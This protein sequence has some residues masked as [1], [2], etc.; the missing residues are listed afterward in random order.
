MNRLATYFQ[1]FAAIFTLA[2]WASSPALAQVEIEVAAGDSTILAAVSQAN[3]GDIL[4]LTTDG[5]L[6]TN[7]DEIKPD[8]PLTIKAADG[9][10]N[11]PVLQNT[12]PDGTKDIIRLYSDLTLIGLE[13]D[14]LNEAKYGIRTGSGSGDAAN[15]KQGYVLKIMDCYFHDIVSGADGN[16]FRAYGSTLA[17]SI[18]VRNSLFE[19]MGKEGVRVRDEDSD[20]RGFGFYNVN[21]F[22][23]SHSTFWDIKNDA[24]S[25][26]GGDEDPN[27]PG[28]EV[29]IDHVTFHNAGHYVINLKDVEDAQVTNSILVGNYDIV[30]ATGKTLGAPWLV[31]GA[32]IAYTDTLNVSDDAV[33][34]FAS[35]SPEDRRN[36]TV[37]SL[38]AVDPMF[39]DPDN[40]DFTLSSASPLIGAGEDGSDL[41]DMR[42]WPS[43][44]GGGGAVHQVAAGQNT[45]MEA[46]EAAAA[47]D[48]IELTDSGGE[49]LNDDQIN[50]EVPLTVRAAYGLADK[51]VIK[52]NEPDEST[53]VVF[54]IYDDLTLHGVEIDGQAG[55]DFNAKYL[56]RID[57]DDVVDGMNL[58]VYDSFLHD[59]VAGSDGNF[60]RQY[61]GTLA[62]SVI[63][64]NVVLDNSGKEGLRIK[65]ESSDNKALG[66]HNV[67]YFEVSNSTISN[68]KADGIYVDGGDEDESTPEPEFKVDG[69]TC[70]NCGFGNGRA[71]FPRNILNATITNSILAHSNVDTEGSVLI[72]GNSSI[73]HSNLFEVSP[74]ILSSGATQ[75]NI[76]NLDPTFADPANLDFTL[77]HRILQ[78]AGWGDP[79]WTMGPVS[80]ED[81][82]V[83]PTQ[84]TLGQNYPNPFYG[85]TAIPYQIDEPGMATLEVFDILGRQITSVANTHAAPGEYIVD[86]SLEGYAAG[87]Y[88]YRL[89]VDD[90]VQHR[91]L[92]LLK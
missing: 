62:D 3:P 60:L 31:T 50:I 25:V 4:V 19:N 44:G 81:E 85:Q 6:Y 2:L 51:P 30:N 33:W 83:L 1:T 88:V 69:L 36:P 37:E 63:F 42:W 41:G 46:V 57:G 20:R 77:G 87:L 68:T 5:G 54:R 75:H 47:G 67:N 9:L 22:E 14:G 90:Q 38:Y 48:I 59:V 23:V 55:T 26:Y 18:I 17:D 84:M 82:I 49:Y 29:L 8:F 76:L 79:R 15:V 72:E 71:I 91:T 73:T 53:R 12:G 78:E 74:I 58:K 52:N 21:Y 34:T 61:A 86:L 80:S 35:G 70:Y 66:I 43:G 39:A 27:T 10:T 56:L 65:D 64:R 13:F 11:R 45:L 89:R 24:I 92:T 32:R 7:P 28:P 40:G 16:A